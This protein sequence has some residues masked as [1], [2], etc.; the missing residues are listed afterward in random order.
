MFPMIVLAMYRSAF[1]DDTFVCSLADKILLGVNALII[2]NRDPSNGM[3]HRR[4][5]Y[6][7][8]DW[9][10]VE[11]LWAEDQL[12]AYMGLLA[13]WALTGIT[14]YKVYADQIQNSFDQVFWS[15]GL[16]YYDTLLNGAMGS[17]VYTSASLS[18]APLVQ[19]MAPWVFGLNALEHG[20]QAVNTASM[21]NLV[22]S[23]LVEVDGHALASYNA[24]LAIG[25]TICQGSTNRVSDMQTYL[26]ELVEQTYPNPLYGDGGVHAEPQEPSSAEQSAWTLL[27]L[28][29]EPGPQ[30]W[31]NA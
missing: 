11:G 14:K 13:A 1:G 31:I 6:T 2:G 8:G 21:W 9:S 19:G 28:M 23:N 15:Q 3:F 5:E 12:W 16:G 20:S 30:S 25:L 27:S 18:P 17:G 10:L 29:A 7:G 4:W 22:G 24:A 26:H